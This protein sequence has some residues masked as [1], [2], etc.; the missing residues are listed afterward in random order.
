MFD[1]YQ[2]LILCLGAF[3][4]YF[5]PA[6][7]AARVIHPNRN[8]IALLNLLAGWTFIGWAL[9]LAW[10]QT[11]P[12][13][14]GL[15]GHEAA[16]IIARDYIDKTAERLRFIDYAA[17]RLRCIEKK[18]VAYRDAE[19]R[20]RRADSIVANLASSDSDAEPDAFYA[21]LDDPRPLD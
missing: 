20:R 9:A 11:R 19:R 5:A 7:N 1:T 21:G 13:E 15:T 12:T 3:V 8:L 17:E 14:S 6:I 16:T 2:M 4:L 18:L 10:S